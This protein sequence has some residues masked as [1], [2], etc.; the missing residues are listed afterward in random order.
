MDWPREGRE[1]VGSRLGLLLGG[2]LRLWVAASI[3]EEAM[4]RREIIKS[5][6]R[7]QI[8]SSM[9]VCGPEVSNIE[10][11]SNDEW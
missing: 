1:L 3:P 11:A 8:S 2:E 10:V 5:W 4:V 6:K 9:G 7:D